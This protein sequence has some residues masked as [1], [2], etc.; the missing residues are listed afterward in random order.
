MARRGEY[1]IDR[2]AQIRME[3]RFKKRLSEKGVQ[4]NDN[5][6]LIDVP[7]SIGATNSTLHP[8][9]ELAQI[10]MLEE[11]YPTEAEG[12]SAKGTLAT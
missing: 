10:R 8:D 9:L 7:R 11:L 6:D 5:H 3:E 2:F 1:K 4:R 12:C